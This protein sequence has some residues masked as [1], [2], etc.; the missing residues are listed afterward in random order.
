VGA[1]VELACGRRT[2]SIQADI[3][4]RFAVALPDARSRCVL[5][6]TYA[7]FA[8]FQR[9]LGTDPGFLPVRLSIAELKESV[10]VSAPGRES[11]IRGGPRF[12]SLTDDQ[13]RPISNNTGTLI[14]Y[15]KSVAGG[16]Q[17]SDAIYVDGLPA[18]SPPPAE[19]ISRISVNDDPFSAEFADGDANLIEIVTKS[20]P[21]R[22]RFNLGGA[23]LGAGGHNPLAPSLRSVDRAQN[24]SV[25]GP[26]P[27]LL[28]TFSL[29]PIW[30]MT[31]AMCR[32]WQFLLR[33]LRPA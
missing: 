29:P 15:A 23:S 25:T 30:G 27:R 12:V 7:G 31:Q 33:R 14:Q 1:K 17:S 6:V 18:S 20:P 11:L 3:Q 16:S 19:M 13:L 4:G 22:L 2:F 26:L 32:S 24:L 10:R 9:A 21:R 5:K 8:P 28:L